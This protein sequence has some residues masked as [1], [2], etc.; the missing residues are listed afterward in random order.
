MR[1]DYFVNHYSDIA[2][3]ERDTKTVYATPGGGEYVGLYPPPGS[4]YKG[5]LYPRSGTLG[6]CAAHNA[7]ISIYPHES[8][9]SYIQQ[10]TGDDSWNPDNMRTYFERLERCQYLP[11]SVVGHGFTGW[12]GTSLTDLRLVVE[13]RQL[14]SLIIAAATGLGKSLLTSLVTTVTGL[15]EI[16][17]LDINSGLPGRDNTTGLY[18]VPI[19]TTPGGLLKSERNGPRD[20]ILQVANAVHPNGTRMYHLDIRLNCLVTKV[21][22]DQSG[23]TPKASG[24][25]FLDGQSLY[26]ADPRAS[27]ASSGTPGSVSATREVILSAGSFNTPQLLKL[28]GIGPSAELESFGIPVVVDL[29]GVGTN[30]QGQSTLR[31]VFVN[32]PRSIANPLQDRYEVGVIAEAQ[33]PF[34]ITENC[35]FTGQPND[36]CLIAY[37]D[38]PIGPN[39]YNTNGLAVSVVQ[40]STVAS[41]DASGASEGVP[42][43]I[44]TGAPANFRG[45][46]PG[47]ST[48]ALADAK[49]WVW[50]VL[51]AHTRN[52]AG[53]VTLR[54][55]D[56]QDVPQINF[57]YFDTGTTAGG[58]DQLDLEA[59]VEAIQYSRRIY[60]DVIPLQSTF[61][62]VWPG[63]NI[64]TTAEVQQWVKD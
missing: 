14:L 4:T 44:V 47:Y 1:W 45:Y 43:L 35:A 29:P 23:A 52:T 32:F 55:A 53:T 58:A 12:F 16:L 49:H 5:I 64:S 24:V 63:P 33:T 42:D 37:E 39:T 61:Q 36:P 50:I 6:G 57:N 54:S 40:K 10:I 60:K 27:S 51:K 31:H 26:R 15:A 19:A 22:F 3:Q 20:F 59:V 7:L 30:M 17:T 2:R 28:S 62:E 34:V 46:F 25:D 48:A 56:P 13:D 8:D 9:W 18:Q 41:Q 38:N 11:N 21:R